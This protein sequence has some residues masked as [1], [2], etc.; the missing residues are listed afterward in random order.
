MLEIRRLIAGVVGLVLALGAVSQVTAAP[1]PQ[2]PDQAEH[3]RIVRYWT[4]DRVARAT[5][6]E[7]AVNVRGKPEVEKGKPGGGG[8]SGTTVTG[9]HW[10]GPSGIGSVRTTVGKVLFTLGG[11]NYVCSGSV[12]SEPVTTVSLVLTAGHCT[13]DSATGFASNWMFV[14]DYEH[15][16]TFSCEATH[17]GCWTATAL[18]TTLAWSVGDLNEDYAFAV[19]GPGGKGGQALQLDATVGANTIAFGASHP[20]QVY[21]FGYPQASPYNGQSLTY[22][23]GT[24]T[25]DAWG[26]STDFGLNCNMTGGSSGGPWFSDFNTQT[27]TGT[28][29]SL[30]S[31]RYRGNPTVSKYMFGPYFDAYTEATFNAAQ[32][33][34]VNTLVAAP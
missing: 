26:G 6:R 29:T 15:A 7:L 9:A 12:V 31:F 24:D 17:F 5:P 22:C 19:V 13:F 2:L 23:A 4:P 21:A 10:T 32:S 20:R 1:P 14:P 11:V 30:N 18:V 34:V 3:E 33:E 25:A 16:K 28:L 8:G 27:G